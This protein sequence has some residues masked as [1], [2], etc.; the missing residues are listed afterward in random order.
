MKINEVSYIDSY[1]VREMCIRE[2]WFTRGN[3]AEY[4]KLFEVIEKVGKDI[5]K[6]DLFG[7]AE[8]ITEHSDY[9]GYDKDE[10]TANVMYVMNRDCV[11]TC[12][13][14]ER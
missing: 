6:H 13:E 1:S 7:L 4:S 2:K 5:N 8:Y 12:Y 11:T 14:I 10:F 9:D 3:N